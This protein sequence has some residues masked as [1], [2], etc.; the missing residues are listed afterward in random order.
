M[1]KNM[2]DAFSVKGKNVLVTGGNR[3]I[4]QGIVQAFA[5]SEANVAIMARDEQRGQEV[6]A[7]IEKYGGKYLFFPGDVTRKEDCQNTIEAVKEE[8]KKL[9]ILVNNAGVCRHKRTLD[10]GPDFKDWYEVID[11]NLHGLFL[12]CYYAAEIMKE[13]GGGSIINITSISAH[14]VNV[15]QW[16]ASYNASKAAAEHLVESLAVEWAPYNIRLNSIEPGYTATELLDLDNERVRQWH[17][18]WR[19]ACPTDRFLTPLEIGALCVYLGS[20]AA[21]YCRGSVFEIDGGYRLPR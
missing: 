3:G 16:Q 4:G 12:M 18:Y 20:D 9:D 11:V 13:Q 14:I 1:I 6:I 17:Q 19:Q 5:Q 10:L 15:P 21:D 7:D 2:K 8:W